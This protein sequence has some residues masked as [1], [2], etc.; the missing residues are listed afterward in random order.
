MIFTVSFGTRDR[1]SAFTLSSRQHVVKNYIWR[2]EHQLLRKLIKIRLCLSVVT[3][4]CIFMPVDDPLDTS[5]PNVLVLIRFQTIFSV[6]VDSFLPAK[7]HNS[8]R[9]CR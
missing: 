8:H 7:M 2:S 5:G 3:I 1:Y 6:H 4:L 9:G